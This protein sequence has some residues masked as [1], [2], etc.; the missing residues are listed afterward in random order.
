M[1]MNKDQIKGRAKEAEG[2]VQEVVGKIV[3]NDQQQ[4]K[5]AAKKNLGK[6]QATLGDAK[7]N[8]KD[9]LKRV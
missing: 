1:S 5:G 7:Q 6:L 3:G 8:L 4:A 2:K 9:S